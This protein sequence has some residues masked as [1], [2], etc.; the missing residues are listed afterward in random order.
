MGDLI[1]PCRVVEGLELVIVNISRSPMPF[2]FWVHCNS[3]SC[4]KNIKYAMELLKLIHKKQAAVF[5]FNL[6][7]LFI[8]LMSGF[9]VDHRIWPKHF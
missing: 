6:N 1:Y 8:H 2:E 5:V 7:I 9:Y 4:I 3:L